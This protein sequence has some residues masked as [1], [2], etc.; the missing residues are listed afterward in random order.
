MSGLV[1]RPLFRLSYCIPS[2][3]IRR[4]VRV[5]ASELS[6]GDFLDFEGKVYQ[7]VG[8]DRVRH[9]LR[10]SM[11]IQGEL[12]DT[13]TGRRHTERFRTEQKVELIDLESVNLFFVEHLANGKLKF[14]DG[15]D[16]ELEADASFFGV[17]SKFFKEGV[18]IVLRSYEGQNVN[19]K[20]LDGDVEFEVK[21][22]SVWRKGDQ[23]N[24]RPK[25]ATL[26]N[27]QVLKVP[28]YI[29][30]GDRIVVNINADPPSFVSRVKDE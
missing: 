27:G 6:I 10:G 12:K 24:P 18:E 13:I 4:D 5:D 20:I 19:Y 22:T 2:S 23:D 15:N 30:T 3:L 11:Y 25:P 7:L 14:R 8:T 28:V 26:D 29:N 16:E 1:R 9:N 21:E 17:A